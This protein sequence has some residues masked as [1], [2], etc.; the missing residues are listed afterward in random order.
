MIDNVA[1]N[2]AW[3]IGMAEEFNFSEGMLCM[4]RNRFDERHESLHEPVGG[5]ESSI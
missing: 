1:L 2:T 4:N 5:E 3:N